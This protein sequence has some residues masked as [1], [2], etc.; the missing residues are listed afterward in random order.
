MH[1]R[2][3]IVNELERNADEAIRKIARSLLADIET[4]F[5]QGGA[6]GI[7]RLFEKMELRIKNDFNEN[8]RKLKGTL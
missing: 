8:L 5:D 1:F 7:A 3:Q 2:E 6:D 4:A